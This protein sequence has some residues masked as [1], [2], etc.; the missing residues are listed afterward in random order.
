V[1]EAMRREVP[2][3]CSDIPVLREVGGSVPRYFDPRDPADAAHAVAAELGGERDGR[4]G[5]ERAARF[6]WESAAQGTWQA[7]ERALAARR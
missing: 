4:E 2:L 5:R 3:A 1:L 6:S 7:Y